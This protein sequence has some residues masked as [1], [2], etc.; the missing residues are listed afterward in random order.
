MTHHRAD[1]DALPAGEMD[2]LLRQGSSRSLDFG[3]ATNADR[4]RLRRDAALR[5][6]PPNGMDTASHV[7]VGPPRDHRRPCDRPQRPPGLTL[8][9]YAAEPASRTADALA[10]LASWTTTPCRQPLDTP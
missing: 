6:T 5:T 4:Q 7:A 2:L 10:L 1:N 3:P 9:L 8:T